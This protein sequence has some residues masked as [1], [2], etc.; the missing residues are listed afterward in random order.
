MEKR[1]NSFIIITLLCSTINIHA[2][3]DTPISHNWELRN[4]Y[5]PSFV[6]TEDQISTAAVY[7]YHHANIINSPQQIVVTADMPFSFLNR[8]HGVGIILNTQNIS[9]LGNTQL[10]LQYS[11]KQKLGNGYLNLGLQAGV[12]DLNYDAAS[13][14]ILTDSLQNNQKKAHVNSADKQV[15]DLALGVSWTG[16][17]FFAGFSVLHLNQPRFYAKDNLNTDNNNAIISDSTETKIHRIYNFLASYNI[18]INNS[19]EIQPIIGLQSDLAQT[20]LQTTIRMEYKKRV[21][22]GLTWIPEE[23]Y[24]IF[25]GTEIQGF[26]LGYAYTLNNKSHEIFAGYKIPLNSYKPRYKPH[27]SIRL[28]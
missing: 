6:G 20:L 9:T 1:L 17:R 8:R 10:A 3:W 27:K 25:A 19:L 16:N 21:S 26:K 2:Q 22:G 11:Y 4:H 14:T 7:R 13:L 12:Y 23:G 28:L 15:L 18:A 24:T 5:N